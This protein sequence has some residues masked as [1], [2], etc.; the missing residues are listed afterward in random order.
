LSLFYSNLAV[1]KLSDRDIDAA[2]AYAEHA[3]SI[4]K[5]NAS[6][7]NTI[8]I[9][10]RKLGDL[11]KAE[12][13]FWHGAKYFD[14]GPTFVRN[15]T[16]LLESQSREVD[17]SELT[18]ELS[19]NNRDH[20]WDWVRAGKRAYKQG[21]FNQAVSYYRRALLIAPELHQL[22]FFAGVASYA[23]AK[24]SESQQHLQQALSLA[25][26]VSDRGNYKRKL[27]AFAR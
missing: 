9:V 27:Q 25:T 19:E 20:L 22:H 4:Y 2:Y 21:K 13:I 6:A 24:P 14:K 23:A 15:Y 1:E 8:G 12:E 11:A 17:L 16:A 3:L 26:E 7:L 18:S 5:E 10:H